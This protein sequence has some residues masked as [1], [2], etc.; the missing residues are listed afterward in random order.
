MT[1]IR[2][3]EVALRDHKNAK[4]LKCDGL[5]GLEWFCSR[6]RLR[7]DR[8]GISLIKLIKKRMYIIVC[9][10]RNP[11]EMRNIDFVRV[12]CVSF[13]FWTMQ[14]FWFSEDFR[15]NQP[16]NHF[17]W[18]SPKIWWIFMQNNLF[19]SSDGVIWTSAAL[20]RPE[21][22]Y[23]F[24]LWGFQSVSDTSTWPRGPMDMEWAR[25]LSMEHFL[26]MFSASKYSTCQKQLKHEETL[27]HP[28]LS[29]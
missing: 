5:V 16:K 28:Q 25:P 11:Y 19:R 26:A 1:E 17:F 8:A 20:Y 2:L 15:L 13:G 27:L 7:S 18:F 6:Q 9:W 24:D 10:W 12:S 21:I 3:F 22:T 29:W 4:N 14:F 23:T